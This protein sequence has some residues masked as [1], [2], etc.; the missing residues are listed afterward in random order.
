MNR[1]GSLQSN[2]PARIPDLLLQ[3]NN[4]F[5]QIREISTRLSTFCEASPESLS[6]RFVEQVFPKSSPLF[7]PLL[8]EVI[9]NGHNLTGVKLRLLPGQPAFLADFYDSGLAQDYRGRQVQVHLRTESLSSQQESGY[10]GL[11]GSSAA[12]R[13]V[14]RKIELY[15]ETEATVVITGETGC[16]KELVANALHRQSAR[17]QG[18]FASINCSAISEQLLESELF[19][20]E[21]G[22]FTGALRAHRGYFEQADGGTLFLDEIGDMPLHTQ[23]KLL[24]VLEEGQL[25]PVG[26][27]R[28]HTVDVRVVA[29]TH[30]ALEQAVSDGRFRADLY[31]RL[32]V[33]R[34][35]VPP[36]RERDEDILLLANHFLHQFN[37]RYQKQIERFTPEAMSIL[38]AYMW[39]G[40]IRELRNLIERLVIETQAPAIGGRALAEWVRERQAFQP[41]GLQ[42]SLR[43]ST[44][45]VPVASHPEKHRVIDIDLLPEIS[46]ALD[47]TR[48]RQAFLQAEGNI[49][50]AAR[51]LGI[52]RATFYRHLS[53]LGLSRQ[54]LS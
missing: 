37:R 42:A 15:A 52:H 48:L 49:A 26:S 19:G 38:K 2:L 6:G 5:W 39:P 33:L 29:A 23:S 18:P 27:E 34:I 21:K 10:A 32:A 43:P 35:H 17:Q 13:E 40:N 51:L 54:D 1:S 31:H 14:F 8:D 50:A 7:P 22:A 16:G 44:A 24:R 41:G 45:L 4:G 28:I 20:H 25:Q 9:L 30:V 47:Q 46:P 36:L 3:K 53:R 11:I 12:I